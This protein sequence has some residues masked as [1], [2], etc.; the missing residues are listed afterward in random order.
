MNK[1]VVKEIG[2]MIL[3]IAESNTALIESRNRKC[4]TL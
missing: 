3:T 2:K 4:V 1:D